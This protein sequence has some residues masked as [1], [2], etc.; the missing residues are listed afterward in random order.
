MN[1]STPA[2]DA[3]NTKAWLARF[4]R[5]VAGQLVDAVTERL[6][7]NYG[8]GT[9]VTLGGQTLELA[10]ASKLFASA[11]QE[12]G[13]H[14]PWTEV[15]DW[16]TQ[17]WPRTLR[18]ELQGLETDTGRSLTAHEVL[19]ASTFHV[20]SQD[21]A[22]GPALAAW[23]RVD[24]GHFDGR[25]DSLSLDGEVTTAT[26]GADLESGS[27]LAGVVLAHSTGDGSF[28]P[29][30]GDGADG[31][32]ESR[33]TGL[34]PYA[35]YTLDERRSVWSLLGY[36]KGTL[37]LQE[38]G[39]EVET[40]LRMRM[41]ALGVRSVL[42]DAP[43][44]GL[45]LALKADALWVRTDSER[46]ARLHRAEA[47]INRLRLLLDGSRRFSFGEATLVPQIE[48]GVRLDGGDAETGTGYEVGTRLRYASGRV[49]VEGTVRTLLEH[50]ESDYEE[51]G[52][53]LAVDIEADAHERGLSLSLAS[54]WGETGSGTD[55]LW[56]APGPDIAPAGK[57]D[58]S[59]RLEA[60]VGYGLAVAQVP[61]VVTP[62]AGLSLADEGGRDARAGLRW[63]ILPEVRLSLEGVQQ[64]EDGD[65]ER[66]LVLQLKIRW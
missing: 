61:G 20:T 17:A 9:Q 65:P 63:Q 27:W 22:G 57:P 60:E 52:A 13:L 50:A 39:T 42:A 62:Y 29:S 55:I 15:R 26:L 2:L 1:F 10:A 33:L 6:D 16:H 21:E 37:E 49:S 59:R 56:M 54:S 32:V 18:A 23:G 7:G 66:E 24:T 28:S 48:L 53:G 14:D 25:N 40:D 31:E 34:Y 44:A 8:S 36:G 12:D 11:Y 30:D 4:G 64:A 51:W 19:L 43:E 45:E 46:H 41:A 35:R 5:T 3:T 58:M 47:D 38:D